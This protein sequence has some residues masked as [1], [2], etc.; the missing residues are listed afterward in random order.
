VFASALAV[1]AAASPTVDAQVVDRAGRVVGPREVRVAALRVR[2]EGRT[3]RLSAGLP[4]GVLRALRA[5]FRAEGSCSALYVSEVRRQRE[6]GAGG[7]VYK[8]GRRL[9]GVSASAP[10]GRLRSGQQVTWFWCV[11]AG[12]CQRTLATRSA[13][14]DGTLR[15]TVTGYDDRGRGVRVAGATVAIRQGDQVTS[16]P[17]GADGTLAVPAAPGAAYEVRATRRGLIPSFPEAV[18]P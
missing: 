18:A 5:P 8:V 17:T 7:W 12:A 1:L 11:Q 14:T 4:I 3:C 2:S 9:P 10:S 16:T 13:I 6:R 15:V